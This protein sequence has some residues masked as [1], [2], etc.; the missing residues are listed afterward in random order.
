[1]QFVCHAIKYSVCICSN[2][3][4]MYALCAQIEAS[5]GIKLMDNIIYIVVGAFSSENRLCDCC[6]LLY[7]GECDDACLLLCGTHSYAY[8]VIARNWHTCMQNNIK[9]IIGPWPRLIIN[10]VCTQFNNI[11]FIRWIGLLPAIF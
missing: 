6:I 11:T 3:I 4:C 9:Y 5:T 1:M 2:I 10:N 8:R 7:R